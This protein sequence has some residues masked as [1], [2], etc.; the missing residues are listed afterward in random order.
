[1]DGLRMRMVAALAPWVIGALVLASALPAGA[2]PA[3]RD[4][5]AAL[6]I[7]AMNEYGNFEF[8]RAQELLE[9][10]LALCQ[11]HRITDTPLARTY[12]NL[13]IVAIGAR[14]DTGAGLDLFVQALNADGKDA[15]SWAGLARALLAI[16]PA[17][18]KD[19][20]DKS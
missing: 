15:A 9:E 11:R 8:D 19:K 12:M 5:V 13:A 4:Q 1:M 7:R 16:V 14:Q 17:R 18:E 2:Q 10:A 3:Q 20:K 6:N